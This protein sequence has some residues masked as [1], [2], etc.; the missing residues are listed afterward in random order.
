MV[1]DILMCT[2]NGEDFIEQ[3]IQS[4]LDQTHTNF[5]LI[6]V[7]DISADRTVEIIKKNVTLR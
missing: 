7:D 6:I 5:R 3:Q 2:Y 4:I 1:V